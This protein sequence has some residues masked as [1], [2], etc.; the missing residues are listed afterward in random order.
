[1][2]KERIIKA[3]EGLGFTQLDAQIYIFLAKEGA[4]NIGEIKSALNLQESKVYRRLKELQ[5]VEI[6]KTIGEHPI[7]YS[8]VTFEQVIDLFIEVKKE[9]TKNIKES[10][11]E[12]LSIW[13]ILLKK[14]L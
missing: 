8:A 3:L 11:E 2:S 14:T 1:L 12:L 7:Q 4:H 13:K 6:V 5:D 9:Q 10:R